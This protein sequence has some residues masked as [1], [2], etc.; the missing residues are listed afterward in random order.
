MPATTAATAT[1]TAAGEGTDEASLASALLAPGRPVPDAV[2]QARRFAVYRNNVVVGLIDAIEATYPAVHALAGADFF[3]AAARE[4]VLAHPPESPVLIAW[5][6]AFADWIAT[7]PPAAGVPYLGDVARLEWA[8]NCAYNAAEAAP[9]DIAALAALPAETIA[10]TRVALHPSLAT[11]AS[12]YPVVSL[13][14]QATGRLER[15][16]LDLATGETALVVRPDAAVD[17][18]TID[19]GTAAFL[20]SLA[21]GGSIAGAAAAA[22]GD[23]ALLAERLAG[24]FQHRLAVALHPANLFPEPPECPTDPRRSP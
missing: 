1:A 10:D 13:W 22:G 9:L 7:F 6:G 2:R 3:R 24:L 16:A 20:D 21:D 12:P 23:E 4:F 19:P 15:S 11:V 5:G 14:A 18:R 8:W 17:V